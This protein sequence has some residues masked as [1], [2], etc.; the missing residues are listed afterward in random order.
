MK[1]LFFIDSLRS[2][3]KER[4]L[5]ELMKVLVQQEN[6]EFEVVVMS[7]DLHYKEILDLGISIHYLIRKTKKDISVFTK[8]YNLCKSYKPDIVHCWDSMTAIYS[9]PAC[10]ILHIKLINGQITDTLGELSISNKPRLRSLITFPLSDLIIGNSEK[11]LEIYNAPVNKSVC[12]HNGF[13]F[14]RVSTIFSKETIR[15][16]LKINTKYLIGMVASFS[17]NKDYETYFKA[18]QL[19]LAKRTDIT[20][21]AIGDKT[22]SEFCN[23]LISDNLKVNIRLLG[24][25]SDV[26]SLVNA[27]DICVLSTFTE[28]I[29]NSILEY[30]ALGKP[31][32]A[33]IGGGTNEIVQDQL[34]GFLI[35]QSSPTELAEKTEILLNDPQMRITMGKYGCDRIRDNFSIDAM[36][37]QYIA[38][39]QKITL[40]TKKH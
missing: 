13:N 4:R 14:L 1:I 8:F 17:E 23:S 27:M 12:I 25:R 33:T 37:S 16:Q 15:N 10:K 3:G 30:M 36:V 7:E 6:I 40:K 21:L 31:V 26:E 2:G 18:A 38:E 39:Y 20:F 11:G 34:S 5:T 35:S 28:G 19:L 29:S 24:Q 32:I 22:D 9:I